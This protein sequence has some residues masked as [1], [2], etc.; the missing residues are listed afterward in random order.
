[1]PDGNVPYEPLKKYVCR[2]GGIR[3]SMH[4]PVRDK[5][6]E[7]AV[8]E[9]P[10]DAPEDK[11]AEVLTARLRVR[12]RQ[13]YG[14]IFLAIVLGVLIQLVVN[15]IVRWIESRRS[16]RALIVAWSASAKTPEDV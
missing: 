12:A 14:S 2:E 1:M 9:F 6:V 4:G 15:A 5:L 8:E 13:K 7:W 11:L 3:L 16:N 10:A